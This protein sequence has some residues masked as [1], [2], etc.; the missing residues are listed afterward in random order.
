MCGLLLSSYDLSWKMQ[1]SVNVNELKW[2]PK[3]KISHTTRLRSLCLSSLATARKND[4]R[5]V[6]QKNVL[7][8][9]GN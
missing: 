7:C 2:L 1:S 4:F 6:L 9:D 8:T 3:K 5:Y